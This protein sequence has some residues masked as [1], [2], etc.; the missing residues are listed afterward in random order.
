M[1][2][3]TRLTSGAGQKFRETENE[4]T[5]KFAIESDFFKAFAFQ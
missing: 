2:D 3:A 5:T 4:E 1:Y